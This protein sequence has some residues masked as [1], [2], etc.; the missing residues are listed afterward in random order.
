MY[1]DVHVVSAYAPFCDAMFVDKE[2]AHLASQAE[3]KKELAGR[4][5]LFS[6]R[7]Q[8]RETFI[9][10][11]KGIEANASPEHLK[12]VREVYGENWGSPFVQ[13]LS[14]LDDRQK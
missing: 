8:E 14:V 13:L 1:N 10:Y 6:L 5:R 9:D 2:I 3:L 4:A 12:L 7:P 11:L